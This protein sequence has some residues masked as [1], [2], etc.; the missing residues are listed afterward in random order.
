MH[1]NIEYKIQIKKIS[2]VFWAR[3]DRNQQN[4]LKPRPQQM[5]GLD[6][7]ELDGRC[8]SETMLQGNRMATPINEQQCVCECVCLCFVHLA[9]F[10]FLCCCYRASWICNHHCNKTRKKNTHTHGKRMYSLVG[11]THESESICS[12]RRNLN[13]VQITCGYHSSSVRVAPITIKIYPRNDGIHQNGTF[14]SLT[15]HRFTKRSN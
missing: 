11:L 3:G 5:S 6:L 1:W 4:V 8:S 2:R 7:C 13:P 14:H 15:Q 10:V 12:S 9:W